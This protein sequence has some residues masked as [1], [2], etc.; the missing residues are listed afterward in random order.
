MDF[1]APSLAAVA[2]AA[3]AAVTYLRALRVRAAE[4]D[5]ALVK[6][7]AS[8]ERDVGRCIAELEGRR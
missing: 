8:L 1:V 6:R 3:I 7:I 2:I 5:A 4:V